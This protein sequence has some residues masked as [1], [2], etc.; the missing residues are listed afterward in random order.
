MKKAGWEAMRLG[1]GHKSCPTT[2]E[3]NYPTGG[4]AANAAFLVRPL[5]RGT[6]VW[7]LPLSRLP[8]MNP[9]MKFHLLTIESCIIR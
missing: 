5:K 7:F 9:T 4:L 3:E 2:L 1:G 8:E 6:L